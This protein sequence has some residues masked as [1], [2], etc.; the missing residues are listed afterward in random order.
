MTNAE[1][2]SIDMPSGKRH[3]LDKNVSPN[4]KP[5]AGLAE[6]KPEMAW[7]DRLWHWLVSIS[8]LGISGCGAAGI[9]SLGLGRIGGFIVG[10]GFVV[11][12]LGFPS[13]AR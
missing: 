13:R 12:L 5:P 9:A 1:L 6:R 10:I 3:P 4:W 7:S 2:G 11:F 8:G